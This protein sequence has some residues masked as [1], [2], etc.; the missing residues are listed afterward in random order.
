MEFDNPNR[1][2]SKRIMSAHRPVS[3]SIKDIGQILNSISTPGKLN[4]NKEE[5]KSLA[6][7]ENDY[8]EKEKLTIKNN[9]EITRKRLLIENIIVYLCYKI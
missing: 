2:V 8:E 1:K 4:Q 6:K 5:Y 7:V 3:K 9:S